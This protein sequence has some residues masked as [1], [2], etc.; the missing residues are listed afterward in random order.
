MK[1]KK[2]RKAE[3]GPACIFFNLE[4]LSDGRL[5]LA[6]N[7]AVKLFLSDRSEQFFTHTQQRTNPRVDQPLV[8]ESLTRT[9]KV[10]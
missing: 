9:K 10:F 1:K 6:T 2:Y 5:N 8:V 4:T 7:F 3:Y